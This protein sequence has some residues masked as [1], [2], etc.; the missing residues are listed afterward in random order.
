MREDSE[1]RPSRANNDS[2]KD[3]A[4]LAVRTSERSK[5]GG[6]HRLIDSKVRGFGGHLRRSADH[7]GPLVRSYLV[8]RFDL[9]CVFTWRISARRAPTPSLARSE[10]EVVLGIVDT[11]RREAVVR[12]R[13]TDLRWQLRPRRAVRMRELRQPPD[14]TMP[15]NRKTES[16]ADVRVPR[17]GRGG[18][19]ALAKRV[20]RPGISHGVGPALP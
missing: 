7:R 4:G 9:R 16:H 11:A 20:A 13:S 12:C 8:L 3:G 6:E 18:I 19:H 14:Y 15:V 10:R 17:I 5:N 2:G 1:D